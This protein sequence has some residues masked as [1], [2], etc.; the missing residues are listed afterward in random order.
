VLEA[1]V[2]MADVLADLW[3]L[4]D[5]ARILLRILVHYKFA[6]LVRDNEGERCKIITEFCDSVLR[7]NASRAVGREPPFS[8]R[9]AKERWGD[10]VERYGHAGGRQARQEGSGHQSGGGGGNA[11]GAGQGKG[12]AMVR[13]RGARF[14]VGSKQFAL[15]STRTGATGRRQA[16]GARTRRGWCMPTSATTT[17]LRQAN[18]ASRSTQKSITTDW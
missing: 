14:N 2:N 5:T 6:A 1:L 12:G 7:E 10:V 8:F 11:G 17:L 18:T 16:A 13:N 3:P 15:I 4:D 9:Q